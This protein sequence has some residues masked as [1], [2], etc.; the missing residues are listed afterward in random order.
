MGRQSKLRRGRDLEAVRRSLNLGFACEVQ[1]VFASCFASD[2]RTVG[3]P[4]CSTLEL[5]PHD[6]RLHGHGLNVESC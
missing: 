4:A 5:R 1:P 6:G 3:N 2:G